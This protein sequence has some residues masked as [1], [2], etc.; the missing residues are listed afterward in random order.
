[1]SKRGLNEL[2]GLTNLQTLS[3][4]DNHPWLHPECKT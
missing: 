4:K 2:N 1:M 3:V